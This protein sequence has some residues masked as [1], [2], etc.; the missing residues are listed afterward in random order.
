MKLQDLHNKAAIGGQLKRFAAATKAKK[1]AAVKDAALALDYWDYITIQSAL[2]VMREYLE[3]NRKPYD[4]ST[5]EGCCE[6][7]KKIVKL[8]TATYEYFKD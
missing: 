6:T 5:A 2:E 1:A 4:V 7:L 3:E 8:R